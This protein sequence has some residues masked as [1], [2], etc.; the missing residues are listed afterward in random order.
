MHQIQPESER[1]LPEV[2]ATKD[3]NVL[4]Q[5]KMTISNNKEAECTWQK[6]GSPAIS[7]IGQ[8]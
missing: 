4:I 7:V 2:D 1:K 3:I 6:T 5:Q 8:R